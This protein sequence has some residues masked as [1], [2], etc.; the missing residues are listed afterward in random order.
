M[1]L[2]VSQRQGGCKYCA[3]PGLN[4]QDESVLYLL[5]GH[6]FM[7]I[8]IANSKTLGTRLKKHKKWGLEAVSLWDFDS[9]EAAYRVE[10]TVI[11]WWRH[12]LKISSVPRAFLPDGWTET[13]DVFDVDLAKVIEF[14][15]NLSE[16]SD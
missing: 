9:G 16:Q 8:G 5:V 7:K 13:A 4:W 12:E 1:H 2:S 3:I 15:N 11:D 6:H 14:I 10:Q